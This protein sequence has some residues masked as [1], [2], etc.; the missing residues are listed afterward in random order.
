[1]RR[2]AK[3]PPGERPL[4]KTVTSWPARARSR[5]AARPESPAPTTAICTRSACRGAPGRHGVEVPVVALVRLFGA[6]EELEQH[7]VERRRV[8]DH[9]AVRCSRDHDELGGGDAI[10]E[11]LAVAAWREDVLIA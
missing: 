8:L 2:V 1:M 6:P 5:A 9:E 10:G 7:T 11:L 4:S 3:R